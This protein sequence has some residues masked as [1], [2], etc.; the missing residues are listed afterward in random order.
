MIHRGMRGWM[1]DLRL[2]MQAG[3]DAVTIQMQRLKGS[4]DALLHDDAH[5]CVA[6][7]AGVEA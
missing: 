4:E 5:T 6:G 3:H 7:G 2:A 1:G